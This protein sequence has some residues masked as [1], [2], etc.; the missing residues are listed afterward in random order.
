MS[1]VDRQIGSPVAHSRDNALSY[2]IRHS[3]P[4]ASITLSS[5]LDRP[6]GY[7]IITP[8]YRLSMAH[9]RPMSSGPA[10]AQVKK[11]FDVASLLEKRAEALSPRDS[12]VS[13]LFEKTP[14][15]GKSPRPA[16]SPAA[17]NG[18]IFDGFVEAVDLDLSR[19]A[20]IV[21]ALPLPVPKGSEK[22]S[23]MVIGQID[24]K[25][26]AGQF[27]SSRVASAPL[28]VTNMQL[29]RREPHDPST[30]ESLMHILRL[31]RAER[32]V[33]L[34]T[35][36]ACQENEKNDS[37]T[38]LS[39]AMRDKSSSRPGSPGKSGLTF[40]TDAEAPQSP[41]NPLSAIVNEFS[42]NSNWMK[43]RSTLSAV[44]ELRR[45]NPM[46]SI[47][48]TESD[49]PVTVKDLRNP[50]C[51]V[52]TAVSQEVS[53]MSRRLSSDGATIRLVPAPVK[54]SLL[55]SEQTV[56]PSLTQQ[57]LLHTTLRD[58]DLFSF[59]ESIQVIHANDHLS[60]SLAELKELEDSS[61]KSLKHSI[62][63]LHFCR[64]GGAAPRSLAE[65]NKSR[66]SSLSLSLC[67]SAHKRQWNAEFQACLDDMYGTT[68]AKVA[69]ASYV[70]MR[71]LYNSFVLF[72][73]GFVSTEL[74]KSLLDQI[75]VVENNII[76]SVVSL[77]LNDIPHSGPK[78]SFFA[79]RRVVDSD[80]DSAEGDSHD[81]ERQPHCTVNSTV[82]QRKMASNDLAV[83]TFLY[84]NWW[85]VVDPSHLPFSGSPFACSRLFPMLST[86]SQSP[87]VKPDRRDA[88][89]FP[90][91]CHV[92]FLGHTVVCTADMG[93][94]G[95]ATPIAELQRFAARTSDV[96][97]SRVVATCQEGLCTIG[98][99]LRVA[100][101][102]RET[103]N[104]GMKV[105]R[106]IVFTSGK[107]LVGSAKEKTTGAARTYLASLATLM[108][109]I[110]PQPG[111][112]PTLRLRSEFTSSMTDA[113]ISDAFDPSVAPGEMPKK[114]AG[115]VL[116]VKTMRRL[117]HKSFSNL[118]NSL[119]A[120]AAKLK[121]ADLCVA[122]HRCGINLTFLGR[123]GD[124]VQERL[125]CVRSTTGPSNAAVERLT[126]LSTV[127]RE[128]LAARAFRF[129][130]AADMRALLAAKPSIGEAEQNYRTT[131]LIR[132]FLG[133]ESDAEV[134]SFWQNR[135]T[136]TI[137]EK[138]RFRSPI[139][140]GDVGVR[141]VLQ[142]LEVLCGITVGESRCSEEEML[143]MT[144]QRS[145][146]ILGAQAREA[147]SAKLGFVEAIVPYVKTPGIPTMPP[148]WH[149]PDLF[150]AQIEKALEGLLEEV[151]A[152]EGEESENVLCIAMRLAEVYFTQGEHKFRACEQLLNTEIRRRQ[153]C[154]APLYRDVVELC[155][156]L[157]AFYN[158]E[159]RYSDAI[160]LANDAIQV[161]ID[162]QTSPQHP[163]LEMMFAV[164]AKSCKDSSNHS[165]TV[166]TMERCV[167][168][169]M[170]RMNQLELSPISIV[171]SGDNTSSFSKPR[172]FVLAS[173]IVD[174]FRALLQNVMTELAGAYALAGPEQFPPP[175]DIIL[176]VSFLKFLCDLG[177]DEFK[178]Y[179]TAP[180]VAT[181]V[182]CVQLA[183]ELKAAAVAGRSIGANIKGNDTS[184][185][186][187]AEQLLVKCNQNLVVARRLAERTA[188]K[189]SSNKNL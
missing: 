68:S 146:G 174:N 86:G 50:F 88:C 178:N 144:D 7:G 55:L 1:T 120:S 131:A 105:E 93:L 117:M 129:C 24:E 160:K 80:N 133:S 126:H 3:K 79:E 186:Q 26:V 70:K 49:R 113:V 142:R 177:L 171:S 167:A 52:E 92:Q 156:N 19:N 189:A 169:L 38:I 102:I 59:R 44:N 6:E 87:P 147:R 75:Q 143:K 41:C 153:L 18:L 165:A 54:S 116:A 25:I 46:Q 161:E 39:A 30:G 109:P 123:F 115:Q 112:A 155:V 48:L 89:A 139:S 22:A 140:R 34:Q 181:F 61:P 58:V 72:C 158:A 57:Q 91:V 180:A 8:A 16:T 122:F 45:T 141:P 137:R 148:I 138:F 159:H 185:V 51:D 63:P 32:W 43:L 78:A 36:L 152:E 173:R 21:A 42:M 166:A 37:R 104:D 176:N 81:N 149:H 2:V 5:S 76:F 53:W 85:K 128:E 11:K 172:D 4:S 12:S 62:T 154:P 14:R 99:H 132:S 127:V 103:V 182:R 162:F 74:Q 35:S 29:Y 23:T 82:Q 108:P 77:P 157:S 9:R 20:G 65:S 187:I 17:P 71:S 98:S 184:D 168:L 84:K 135:L 10:L 13:G 40:I 110:V 134:T 121:G 136:P 28:T 130:W 145:S 125:A 96:N 124:L 119:D 67:A 90:L 47:S 175:I 163:L 106:D 83:F 183:D 151:S 164:A 73:V 179:R 188:R 111:L 64:N 56:E 97:V 101:Y 33:E 100:P 107:V 27:A 114:C 66:S 118:L 95:S 31:R 60:V 69:V 94:M 15:G 170:K 150:S